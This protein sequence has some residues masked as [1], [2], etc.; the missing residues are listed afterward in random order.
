MDGMQEVES[1]AD[2]NPA[3]A[4]TTS[5]CLDKC[6]QG[7]CLQIGT[8]T[9]LAATCV[10]KDKPPKKVKKADVGN[11]IVSKGALSRDASLV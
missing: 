2:R 9:G 8:G 4:V 3:V 11:N 6:K 10:S 7:P 5:K 1:I